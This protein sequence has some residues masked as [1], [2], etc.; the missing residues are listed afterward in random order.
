[1]F[2]L[3]KKKKPEGIPVSENLK[4]KGYE[5]ERHGVEIEYEIAFDENTANELLREI[6]NTIQVFKRAYSD[7]ILTPD[8]WHQI[9]HID[10]LAHGGDRFNN[11][12]L[13]TTQ[14]EK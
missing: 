10:H 8:L 12:Q 14:E 11:R 5:F 4:K 3:F 13:A 2:N 7:R 6:R 1:M 9:D